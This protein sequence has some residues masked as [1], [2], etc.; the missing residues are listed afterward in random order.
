MALT[1][2]GASYY[3]S[4]AY[5]LINNDNTKNFGKNVLVVGSPTLPLDD[6]TGKRVKHFSYTL[7]YYAEKGELN[8]DRTLLED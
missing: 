5:I 3:P 2:S 6:F 4:S 7:N 1:L 8:R